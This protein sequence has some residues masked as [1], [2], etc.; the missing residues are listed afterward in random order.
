MRFAKPYPSIIPATPEVEK[1]K[2]GEAAPGPLRS[3][4]RGRKAYQTP[5]VMPIAGSAGIRPLLVRNSLIQ[6]EATIAQI[7]A[8][9]LETIS[10]IPIVD[11][12]VFLLNAALHSLPPHS[13][14]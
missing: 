13:Y 10:K 4:R 1:Y 7:V 6:V 8:F 3:C 12:R 14:F 11:F 5:T 9:C 2:G